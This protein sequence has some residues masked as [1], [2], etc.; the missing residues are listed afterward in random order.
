M[1]PRAYPKVTPLSGVDL[2]ARGIE[3]FNRRAF[4][5]C[6]ELLEELW[7]PERGPCRFF[8]QGIIHLA[9]GFYH[10]QQGN[11]VGTERQLRKGL[12]KL[13]GYLPEFADVDTASL[14]REGIACLEAIARDAKIERFP[15]IRPPSSCAEPPRPI[16][17]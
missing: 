17:R 3:L 7:R 6:H 10:Y 9:V 4:F 2:F 1:V 16:R 15:T 12:K 8:L 13:A 5:D 11:R 14:S